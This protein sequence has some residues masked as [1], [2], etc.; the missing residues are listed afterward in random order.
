MGV[1]LLDGFKIVDGGVLGCNQSDQ[2]GVLYAG[3]A[4]LLTPKVLYLLC[5]AFDVLFFV[6]LSN[7]Y[8]AQ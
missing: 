3:R 8:L 4:P 6:L 7:L 5:F 1:L 2:L